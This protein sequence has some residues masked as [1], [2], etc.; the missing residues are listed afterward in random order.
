MCT[1]RKHI[2]L[3]E[4]ASKEVMATQLQVVYDWVRENIL[5]PDSS[6]RRPF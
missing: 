2:P 4:S 3:D 6:M 5:W 1:E